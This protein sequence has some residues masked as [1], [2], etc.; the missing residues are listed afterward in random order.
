MPV[1]LSV[2]VWTVFCLRSTFEIRLSTSKLVFVDV[3]FIELE[4]VSSNRFL[5]FNLPTF[6]QD[7]LFIFRRL[8]VIL[9]RALYRIRGSITSLF[10]FTIALKLIIGLRQ[11]SRLLIKKRI[12]NP[13]FDVNVTIDHVQSSHFFCGSYAQPR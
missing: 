9:K 12:G 6:H 11:R 8:R 10:E 7:S 4:A 5:S 3:R 13:S 2:C 1:C